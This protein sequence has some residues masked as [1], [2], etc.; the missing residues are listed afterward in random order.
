LSQRGGVS[1]SEEVGREREEIERC[2]GRD[3]AKEEEGGEVRI[4]NVEATEKC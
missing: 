3:N 1:G 4:I 2:L